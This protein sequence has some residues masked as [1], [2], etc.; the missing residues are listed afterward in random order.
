M[1][2]LCK[3]VVGTLYENVIKTICKE[4]LTP[5]YSIKGWKHGKLYN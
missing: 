2:Q 5:L 3:S 1:F 4:I